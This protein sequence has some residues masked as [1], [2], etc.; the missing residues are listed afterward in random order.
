S[1]RVSRRRWS[2]SSAGIVGVLLIGVAATWMGY[3]PG[4]WQAPEIHAQAPGGSRSGKPARTTSGKGKSKGPLLVARVNNQRIPR[5]ELA[6]ECLR[7]HLGDVLDN[8]INRAI[9]ETSCKAANV[10]V[11]EKD[12]QEE[13]DRLAKS[14]KISKDQFL[15]MLQDRRDITPREYARDIIWP[16]LA[17][18]KLANRGVQ[19]LPHEIRGAF[20]THYGASV[21]ARMIVLEKLEEAQQVHRLALADPGEFKRLAMKHSKDKYT[22]SAGGLMQPIRKG[23]SHPDMEKVAFSLK[24]GEISP[25]MYLSKRHV[26]IQCVRQ[27]P[28]ANVPYDQVAP[29]LE[30][31]IREHKLQQAGHD[32]FG[33]L[34]KQSRVVRVL[35]NPQLQQKHPGAAAIVNNQPIKISEVE[36]ACIARHGKETLDSMIHRKLLEQ[37]CAKRQIQIT[38]A[39]IDAEIAS[40]AKEASQPDPKKFLEVV[41]KEQGVTPDFYVREVAWPTVALKKMVAGKGQITDEDLKKAFEANYGPRVKL[42][43]MYFQNQRR[44]RDVWAT[45]SRNPT[46]ANFARLAEEHSVEPSTRATGGEIPPL[47]KYSGKPMLE[48]EAFRMKDGDISPVIQHGSFFIILR[49]QGYTKPITVDFEEVRDVMHEHVHQRK[50]RAAMTAEFDAV[51]RAATID[52]ILMG[53][54]QSPKVD[55]AAKDLTQRVQR[56]RQRN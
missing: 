8:L 6:Q 24:P 31:R 10:Q 17:L 35:G 11:S 43:V 42:R 28:A 12:V 13:I 56:S 45:I 36:D 20:E 7:R 32:Q 34:K 9:I 30:E 1:T 19:V 33:Q 55:A 40:A 3:V 53:T 49:C 51:Q 18:R 5:A 41:C 2:V 14:F 23:V 15:K 44:A 39:D 38:Q 47:H 21:Q 16:T 25:I 48:R 26:F 29:Q 37:A 46:E 54:V 4:I 50:L 22:A 27:F 52:N